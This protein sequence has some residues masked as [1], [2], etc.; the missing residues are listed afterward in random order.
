MLHQLLHE[1]EQA[2]GPITIQELSHRLHLEPG[3]VVDMVA[4]WVR[5]G[6]LSSGATASAHA[7]HCGGDC[8]GTAVCHFIARLPERYEVSG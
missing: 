6:R 7:H 4:F 5:K 8:Q 2:N 1:I 3:V